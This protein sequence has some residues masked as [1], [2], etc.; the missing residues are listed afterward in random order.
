M[1]YIAATACS[2]IGRSWKYRSLSSAAILAISASLS[3]L[4][5]GIARSHSPGSVL[6]VSGLPSFMRPP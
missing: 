3:L 4:A 5:S 1:P 6:P 2:S